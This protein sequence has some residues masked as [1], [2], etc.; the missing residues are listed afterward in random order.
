MA[1]RDVQSANRII[2]PLCQFLLPASSSG[3]FPTPPDCTAAYGAA[4]LLRVSPCMW[5][6]CQLSS[7]SSS[8]S[9]MCLN[10]S[11]DTHV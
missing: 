5:L 11:W 1:L 3:F 2:R 6:S 4:I 9:E 8:A 7:A 10:S